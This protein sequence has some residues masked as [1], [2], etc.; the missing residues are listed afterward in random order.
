MTTVFECWNGGMIQWN[1]MTPPQ[2]AF[3]FPP[4]DAALVSFFQLSG[5]MGEVLTGSQWLLNMAG[6]LIDIPDFPPQEIELF[7]I[8]VRQT[9]GYA[10][11]PTMTQLVNP[12]TGITAVP[13]ALWVNV[14]TGRADGYNPFAGPSIGP[15]LLPPQQAGA[16]G[17]PVQQLPFPGAGQPPSFPPTAFPFSTG[18]TPSAPQ[19]PPASVAGVNLAST[20]EV[21]GGG[22]R[23][24]IE[25]I[26]K[27]FEGAGRIADFLGKVVPGNGG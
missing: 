13:V 4:V 11:V 7:T 23:S 12:L 26:G 14:Q 8:G 17:A 3:A 20:G 15:Q 5:R 2:F 19:A 16:W 25:S 27:I 10:A 6:Q 18:T 24:T 1:G 9:M 21:R 22:A